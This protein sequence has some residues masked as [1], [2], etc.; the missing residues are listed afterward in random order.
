M[1]DKFCFITAINMDTPEQL[2]GFFSKF[3]LYKR[4]PKLKLHGILTPFDRSIFE[5]A[6]ETMVLITQVPSKC[7]GEPAHPPSLTRAFA[8]RTHEV[9]KKTKGP[10]KNETSSPTGWLRM[11]V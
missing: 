2:S 8:V 6:H 1:Q 4:Y 9:W 7:S 3:F 5:P 10:T 11:P